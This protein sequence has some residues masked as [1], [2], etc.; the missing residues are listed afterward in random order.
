MKAIRVEN[1]GKD[2]KLSL[3]DAPKPAPG[4]GEVLIEVAA[5]GL[6]H[7]DL[8]QAKGMYPPPP[9]ASEIL[10]MEVSGTIVELGAGVG[11]RKVGDKVC[12]LIPG[13]GYAQFAAA[14]AKCLL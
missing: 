12:A 14:S 3:H 4:A 8:A 11:D 5:A 1:P 10:G 2:Y 9:G 13:G 6:H 7:G